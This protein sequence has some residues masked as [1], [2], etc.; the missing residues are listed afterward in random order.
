MDLS[1]HRGVLNDLTALSYLLVCALIW[2]AFLPSW[3]VELGVP[4]VFVP[5][6]FHCQVQAQGRNGKFSEM[7]IWQSQHGFLLLG[8][9]PD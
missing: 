6:V 3:A 1:Y 2:P 7:D 9:A 4:V 5:P 8:T